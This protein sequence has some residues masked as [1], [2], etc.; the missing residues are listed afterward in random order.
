ML[1]KNP[2]APLPARVEDLLERMTRSEKIAQLTQ[3][4][5]YDDIREPVKSNIRKQGLGSRILALSNLAGNVTERIAEVED[6]NELQR[7]AVEESRL[8]IPLLH[9]RDVIHGHRT[10]FPIPLAMAASWDPAL[11]EEAF[12]I[13]AR[14]AASAGVHWTFAP[15]LDIGRDPRWGRIIEGFGE[16]P[17]LAARM[18]SVAVR[19][20]QGPKSEEGGPPFAPDRLLACAKHYIGYGA[21]E[22]GRDY[23]TAEI[24]DNTLRNVYLPP[25]KAAVEAGVGSVMSAFHDLNG[26]PASGSRYLLTDLLRGELGFQGFVVSDWGSVYELTAHRVAADRREAALLAFDAGVDMDMCS[27]CFGDHLAE[28]VESGAIPESKLDDAVRRVLT[29]KF[30]LGLFEMPYTDPQRGPQVQFTDE[31]RAVAQRLAARSLVLLKNNGILPLAKD[32]HR[33]ALIGPLAEQRRALLGSWV[34]DGLIGETQTLLEAFQAACPQAEILSGGGPLTDE[35]LMAAA[36]ADVVILAVGESNARNGEA[37]C[38]ASLDL[39]AGQDALIE[40]VHGLG[41][42]MVLLVLAGRPINLP[43][44]VALADALLYAW[45]PG[46]LGAAAIAEVLFGETVPSGKLP[47]S[48]P[49]AEG[50]IPIHYNH[51]STGRSTTQYHDLPSTPLFPFGFGLSYTTFSYRNLGVSPSEIQSGKCVTVSVTVT[52]TGTCAGEEVAQCYVHDC[53]ASVTRPERELKGFV[54]VRLEPGESQRVEFVLGPDELSFYGRDGRWRLEPGL[55]KVGV[56][57]DCRAELAVGF[58]VLAPA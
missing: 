22:G 56:G 12:A 30:R 38:V 7:V 34:N 53:V 45:H 13:S 36:R 32:A 6:L 57:G 55:F 42:P 25:F 2:T 20:I 8:G 47:V 49:R 35:M 18:A 23:N 28:L 31:H 40:A 51:K 1:Y 41:K 11:V 46:S 24:S 58:R 27:D 16:D 26:E 39:P 5:V 19:G 21:A 37:N 44:A 3:T 15:M 14:E 17:Y 43:R 4:F 29:A 10:V 54:R 9:G 48:F 50:Q 33:I 52:N